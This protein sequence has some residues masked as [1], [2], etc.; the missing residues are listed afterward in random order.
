[1]KFLNLT[2]LLHNANLPQKFCAWFSIAPTKKLHLFIYLIIPQ[3]LLLQHPD[4]FIIFL[5]IHFQILLRYSPEQWQILF[6]TS[7]NSRG[8][9]P[10]AV[11][12]SQQ[13]WLLPRCFTQQ[14]HG[15]LAIWYHLSLA[16]YCWSPFLLPCQRPQCSQRSE[17]IFPVDFDPIQLQILNEGYNNI[18][19]MNR[20]NRAFLLL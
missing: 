4:F 1:M 14:N 10:R 8:W 17:E 2:F 3:W 15:S 13:L 12:N 9:Y 19:A 11:Y 18:V 20:A 7:M 6:I 5:Y 16:L